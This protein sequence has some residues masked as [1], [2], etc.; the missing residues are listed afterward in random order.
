MSLVHNKKI[1]LEYSIEQ[2]KVFGLELLG[3]EVK[4][5]RKGQGSLEGAKIVNVNNE[6]FLVG[7]YI[8][9]FQEKNALSYKATRSRK[10]LANKKEI[11]DIKM[12]HHGNNLQI[13]P[14]GFFDQKGLIKL[15]CGIGKRLKKQDKRQVIRDKD[16]KRKDIN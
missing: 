15:E 11:L 9:A 8:P 16:D 5:L 14:I 6:L 7:G 2:K 4:S 3:T 13:F 10:L 12:L 1:H